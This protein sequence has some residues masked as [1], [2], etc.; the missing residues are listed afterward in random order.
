MSKT[1]S[2]WL[3]QTIIL[4]TAPFAHGQQAGKVYRI[5]Y[6]SGTDRATNPTRIE[7]FR[8]RL[9]ELGYVE[10]KNVSI[11]YRYADDKLERMSNLALELTRLDV[12][13][14]VTTGP[15]VLPAKK[16]S[17]TIPIVFTAF[18]DPVGSGLVAS[19]AQPGGNVTGLSVISQDLDSKRLELLREA[20]P[21]ISRVALLWVPSTVRGNPAPADIA[22]AAKALGVTILSLEVR[23]SE[24]FDGAFDRAKKDRAHA[25]MT[26]P[27][28]LVN[29]QQRRVLEFAAKN[30]LPTMYSTSEFVEGGGLMSYGPNNHDLFRRAADFVDKILKGTKPADIPVEQASKFEFVVNLRTA[31]QLGLAVPPEVLARANRI[32]R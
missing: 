13:V 18:A 32:I 2:I 31:K 30:R 7:A 8:Q 3:L 20:F 26:T 19:L 11:D 12:D 15:A 9:H 29:S 28:P 16:A 5:G 21:K 24:D 6:L 23:R 25:L 14:I 27:G 4:A 10:G 17:A 1:I 22:A